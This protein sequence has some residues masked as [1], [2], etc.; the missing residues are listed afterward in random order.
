VVVLVSF[1]ITKYLRQ[2]THKEKKSVLVLGFGRCSPRLDKPIDFRSMV[3]QWKHVVKEN[4]S[5]VTQEAKLAGGRFPH[6]SLR[7]CLND[8][9]NSFLLPPLKSSTIFA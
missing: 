9:N 1:T 8:L 7:A 6:S 4:H 2:L 5:T 3:R